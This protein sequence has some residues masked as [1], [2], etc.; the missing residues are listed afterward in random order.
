MWPTYTEKIVAAYHEDELKQLFEAANEDDW[1]LFKFF[2]SSG[3]RDQEVA[4]ATW[5]DIN[6]SASIYRHG[7]ARVGSFSEGSRGTASTAPGQT[8]GT[9]QS[10]PQEA[11]A[12][13]LDFPER[14]RTTGATFPSA[15]ENSCSQGA[16][17]LRTLR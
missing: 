6:F 7:Q 9:A 17:Q 10:L 8:G 5:L 15:S 4:T 11:S 12:G 1:M 16:S 2:L 3:C 14:Q 13:S